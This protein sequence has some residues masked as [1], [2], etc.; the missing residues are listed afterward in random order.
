M[1]TCVCEECVEEDLDLLTS[2]Q[3]I[4]VL[5]DCWDIRNGF[6][7]GRDG[8]GG[9]VHCGSDMRA[10]L[11]VLYNILLYSSNTTNI[12]FFKEHKIVLFPSNLRIT[13]RF[14]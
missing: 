6:S 5:C 10:L 1:D 9:G 13:Y 14:H 11:I 12:F 8:L 7:V 3:G 4:T 2:A